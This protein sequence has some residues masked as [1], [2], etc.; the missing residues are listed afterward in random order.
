MFLHENRTEGCTSDA[1]DNAAE[2][3]RLEVLEWLRQN[4]REGWTMRAAAGAA[5]GGH[6]RAL[7]YLLLG[8]KHDS[9]EDYA[10]WGLVAGGRGSRG[11][12]SGRLSRNATTRLAAPTPACTPRNGP[13]ISGRAGQLHRGFFGS[14][15]GAAAASGSVASAAAVWSR[16]AGRAG[17]ARDALDSPGAAE[18]AID[19]L[20]PLPGVSATSRT[21]VVV[22]NLDDAAG[23][24]RL[25]VLEWARRV[26][27]GSHSPPECGARAL[28]QVPSHFEGGG[29]SGGGGDGDGGSSACSSPGVSRA[30]ERCKYCSYVEQYLEDIDVNCS[31]PDGSDGDSG[32]G[33]DA[34]AKVL[35]I[36]V[37]IALAR[38]KATGEGNEL[39]DGPRR[40]PSV[41]DAG[42]TPDNTNSGSEHSG[43]NP[44]LSV[45]PTEASPLPIG[46]TGSRGDI[47]AAVAAAKCLHGVK[48]VDTGGSGWRVLSRDGSASSWPRFKV[49]LTK[50]AVANA[51]RE[52]QLEVRD[53]Y[54]I[55]YRGKVNTTFIILF[56]LFF[57][58]FSRESCQLSLNVGKS[59]CPKRSEKNKRHLGKT[60]LIFLVSW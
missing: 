4:R 17:G 14:P 41:S 1:M 52:G 19:G 56:P 15:P 49:V 34:T 57:Y 35:D 40:S 53:L 18:T 30:A 42:S 28:R 26:T 55:R 33:G 6:L 25:E 54:S 47:A 23:A 13:I 43:H 45:A 27:T 20:Q 24:G 9:I 16:A 3:N 29:G 2:N 59:N 36:A 58:L 31:E 44:M 48:C 22:L 37:E 39:R 50:Q 51:A 46:V 60:S 38:G 12:G 32:D 11:S 7:S 21:D 10:D 5:R 8:S